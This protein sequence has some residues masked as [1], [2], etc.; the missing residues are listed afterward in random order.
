MKRSRIMGSARGTP[1]A[2]ATR[3]STANGA[4]ETDGV[5]SGRWF[6]YCLRCIPFFGERVHRAGVMKF[7]TRLHSGTPSAIRF[8]ASAALIFLAAPAD[9]ATFTWDGGGADDNFTTGLNWAGNVA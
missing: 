8:A 1:G 2:S 9:G 7:T 4:Y 6:H 3:R 5:L